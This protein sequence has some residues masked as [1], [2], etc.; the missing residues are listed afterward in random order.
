MIPSTWVFLDKF[1]LTPSG[2]IDRNSLPSP[3]SNHIEAQQ[4]FI[5]PRDELE[6]RLAKLWE[7]LLEH[8]PIGIN[9]NFFEVGGHSML[10]VRLITKLEK[11]FDK[12]LSLALIFHAPTIAQMASVLRDQGWKPTWSSLVPIRS[13]GNL[14]PLFCVHA[15]GGAFF[16]TRFA[17]YLSP[18]QPFYGL[19]ARGLDGTEP[20]FTSV[21][22][23]A[24]HYLKEIRSIQ[25]HG[26]YIIGGF[27]MGGVVIYEMAQQLVSNG[28]DAPLL[29]FIDAPSPSYFAEEDKSVMGK[30]T[31]LTHLTL[32]S[33]IQTIRVRLGQ[34][35]RWLKDNILINIYLLFNRP[36][37]PTLRIHHVR[38][39]NRFISDKYEPKPYSGK[40]TVLHASEQIRRISP[41]P[42]LGWGQYVSGKI[43]DHI[44]PGNHETILHEPNVQVLAKTLQTCI[45]HALSDRS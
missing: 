34:R 44:V 10:V 35:Y 8:A 32:Q 40:I 2:K 22:D 3:T 23:M 42:T 1:P 37:T 5:A 20:P 36:L 4:S 38:E 21:E 24:K 31:K 15:D 33:R 11:E 41:D 16:Y 12:S 27:S 19:Q 25:P 30:L 29:I 26:P 14:P 39:T 17:D 43:S 28:E 45:D 7:Q 18:E 13:H 6:L 9:D